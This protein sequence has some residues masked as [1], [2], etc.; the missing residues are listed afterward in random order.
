MNKTVLVTAGGTGGHV[1]PALVVAE[2]LKKYYNVIWVGSTLGIENEIVPK[3]NIQLEKIN[4]S[5][6]RKKGLFKLFK[7]PFVLIRAIYQAIKII[8]KHKPKLVI[9]FGG[10]ASFP[11]AVTAKL[12]NIPLIIHEQNS[13]AGLTNK[14]LAKI[15]NQV[16]VAFSGVLPSKKTYVVGN[17]IRSDILQIDDIRT[18]YASRSGGLNILILGGSLGANI[19]NEK[20]PEVFSKVNNV[21]KIIHQVGRGDI[22]LVQQNY[23]KININAQIV[24]FIDNMALVYNDIDLII[25]RSGALTVSELCSVGISAIFIPYPFAVDDHQRFN[26]KPIV[27]CGAAKMVLQSEFDVTKMAELINSLDRV[28]CLEMAYAIKQFAIIDSHIQI[29]NAVRNLIK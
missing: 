11:V 26:A 29:T 7:L 14:I 15:A 6:L 19:F 13:V 4:I 18:R 21:A 5:G 2:E 12:F 20:F 3:N 23:N 17:P 8:I 9:S 1:F 16:L 27:D 22:D 24:K 10:Y 25:C 28:S